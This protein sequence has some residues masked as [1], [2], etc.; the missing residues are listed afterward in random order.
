[1]ARYEVDMG[2]QN[3][4]TIYTVY[5]KA[6]RCAEA[7]KLTN[8]IFAVIRRDIMESP[9]GPVLIAGDFNIEP[10]KLG[11]HA[12]SCG[13]SHLSLQKYTFELCSFFR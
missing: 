7:E 6:G 5:C 12:V 4:L 2:H 8:S 11:V 9:M 13:V 3:T 1:M 10:E